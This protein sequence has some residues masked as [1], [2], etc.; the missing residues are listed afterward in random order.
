M[1]TLECFITFS[2]LTATDNLCK[3]FKTWSGSKL[4]DT[5]VVFPKEFFEKVNF[6]KIQQSTTKTWKITKHAKR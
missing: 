5:L 6:E 2:L 3:Q 4:F 1:K